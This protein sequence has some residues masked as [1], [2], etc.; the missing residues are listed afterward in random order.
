MS[1]P[2]SQCPSRFGQCEFVDINTDE[3][4]TSSLYARVVSSPI[5]EVLF[6]RHRRGYSSSPE[7]SI[8]AA[9]LLLDLGSLAPSVAKDFM[10]KDHAECSAPLRL[11][12]D[13]HLP[14]E[15]HGYIA[16]SYCHKQYTPDKPRRVVTP[17]GALPFGWTKEVEQFPLPTSKAVFQ[18]VLKERRIGEGL[19]FDQVCIDD[20]D[21]DEHVA[22]VGAIDTIY[23][24]ARAVVVA[25]DDVTATLEEEQFL[26]C[27]AEQYSRLELPLGQQPNVGLSPPLMHQYPILWTFLDHVLN[28]SWFERAW[29]AHE[30]RLGEHHIFI[31]PCSLQWEGEVQTVMRF[32][33]A[34]FFHLLVLASE[35]L[36]SLPAHHTKIR[37]L[38]DF[39]RGKQLNVDNARPDSPQ[40]PSSDQTSFI[41]TIA[42]T[43]RM[44]AGGNPRLPEYQRRLDAN[45]D[46]TS[47]ALNASG[48]PLA[49]TSPNP[50]SRPNI[51]DECLR[52]LLLV[53]L[54][55]RDPMSLCTTGTPLQLHDGS[56]SWLCR[57]TPLDGNPVR[58][59][60]PRFTNKAYPIAQRSDGIAEYAQLDL[61]FLELPHRTQPNPQF[62][63]QVARARTLIDLCAQYQLDGSALWNLW[64]A[65][66][67]V[68]ALTMRN[69]FIQTLACVFECG[70]QWLL[71]VSSQ[72]HQ[73][74]S[75]ALNAYTIGMLLNP[76]LIIQNYILLPEG[77]AAFSSLLTL[78]STVIT[79]GIPWASGASERNYGPLIITAPISTSHT[80]PYGSIHTHSGKAIIFAPFAHS[81]TLLVAVPEVVK[82]AHYDGLA[83]GW[84]LTS[85]NPYT[86]SPK[87]SVSW[88]LQSKGVVF[89]DGD[90][91]AALERCGEGDVRNHRVYGP[92]V[93]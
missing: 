86:G 72:L 17:L 59:H 7:A 16:M 64:Q 26:R 11:L 9:T 87:Q 31:L 35:L 88:T 13:V 8:D 23:K 70:T 39:F 28:S 12:N 30:M 40:L 54:A 24:N 56:V 27:Y 50:L 58:N 75:T 45:R 79:S 29:C 89:G 37:S 68:R 66:G 80:F 1:F 55:A 21:E 47:I 71:E 42:E 73:R 3:L 84:I 69:I 91:N 38:H 25:L 41:S 36:T 85:M 34:F 60:M 20:E 4:D 22:A 33:S 65:P 10:P 6:S 90:F 5:R 53:S 67:H 77:Q 51:E 63:S 76:H 15:E 93:R 92:E 46:K 2:S 49:L 32:T 52:S 19:W 83:R 43:F 57:P 18:A 82:D 62:T 81:K 14:D 44:Q 48:L 74:G 61:I 78:I